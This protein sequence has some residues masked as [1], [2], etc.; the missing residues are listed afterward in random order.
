MK[1]IDDLIGQ[2][3]R[4][5]SLFPH[6]VAL[7]F[8]GGDFTFSQINEFNQ[9]YEGYKKL[10]EFINTNSDRYNGAKAQFGTPSEYFHEI[11]KRQGGKF[12]SLVGD[13]FPYADIFSTGMPAY[14][15]GYFTTRPFYKLMSRELEHN[16]RNAEILY[17]IAYNKAAKS[18]NFLKQMEKDYADI[19][20]VEYFLLLIL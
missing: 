2:Y 3:G 6:N 9:E 17:T 5:A 12:P 10:I 11:Q 7:V 19:V 16:L 8:V 14:W 4:T 15:T 18:G 20:E 13:F 1:K